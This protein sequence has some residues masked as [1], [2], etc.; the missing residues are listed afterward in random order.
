MHYTSSVLSLFQWMLDID[1]IDDF[2]TIIYKDLIR[3]GYKGVKKD[4]AVLQYYNLIKRK[5]EQKPRQV[6][7]SK[8]FKCPEGYKLALVEF[9]E[10]AK[11]GADLTPY[12][13][14]KL[15]QANYHDLL[16]N[17]WGVQHFHLSRRYRDDG[18]VARSPY[19]IFAK[20]TVDT[21]YMIQ[22]YNHNADDVF[23][24]KELIRILCD[25]WPDMMEQYHIQGAQELTE[26]YNDH[27]YNEI[28]EAHIQ[29]FV[30]LGENQIYGHMGG[31]IA[32]NGASLE[33]LRQSDYWIKR[34]DAVQRTVVK[35]AEGIA[36]AISKYCLE[37]GFLLS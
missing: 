27:E 12:L 7:Y 17:D 32:S 8:E 4:E 1:L 18:L 36:K 21:I 35:E 6:L 28:R 9:E 19:L 26:H 10:K 16:L 11:K 24:R 37:N 3:A 22:V 5:V 13:T 14:E 31:G 2:K 15:R 20:V 23:S 30:E 34:L 25:N 33:V 29:T